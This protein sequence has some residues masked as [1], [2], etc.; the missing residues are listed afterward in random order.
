MSL[1][2]LCLALALETGMEGRHRV[3]SELLEADPTPAG[4]RLRRQQHPSP[5]LPNRLGATQEQLLS[6]KSLALSSPFYVYS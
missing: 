2:P 4:T 1:C 6:P 3:H 5:A